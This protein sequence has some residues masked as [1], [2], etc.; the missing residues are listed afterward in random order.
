MPYKDPK[1]E[2]A[3]VARYRQRKKEAVE[4]AKEILTQCSWFFSNL[5]DS[6]TAPSK[7]L[8]TLC[9]TYAKTCEETAAALPK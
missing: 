5:P 7:E 4:K 3:K 2:A 1:Q 8:E 6:F 9:A